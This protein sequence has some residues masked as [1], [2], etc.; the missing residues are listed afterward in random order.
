MGYPMA[1][2]LRKGLSADYTL[3]ICDVN[4]EALAKF[5]KE[6]K[7]KGPI[8]VVENG[9]EAVGR[10]VSFLSFAGCLTRCF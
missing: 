9:H 8:E 3:L 4:K 5:Q 2:N 7:G 6:M 10:A 1:V